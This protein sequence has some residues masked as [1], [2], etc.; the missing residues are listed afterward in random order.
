MLLGMEDHHDARYIVDHNFK[1]LPVNVQIKK[2][3][4]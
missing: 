2:L 3:N 1:D 4:K